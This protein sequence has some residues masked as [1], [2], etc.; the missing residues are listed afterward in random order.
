M[1]GEADPPQT[2]SCQLS[3]APCLGMHQT[4]T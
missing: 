1:L 2:Y 4:T 3:A